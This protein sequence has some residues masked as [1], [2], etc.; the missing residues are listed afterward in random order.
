[1]C[2][3]TNSI[4]SKHNYFLRVFELKNKYRR[5][6]MKD[7]SKQ[8]IVRQLSSYLIEK[9]I[10]FRVISIEFEKSKGNCSNQLI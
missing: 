5:F 6:S 7:K 8:K 1:M 3:E 2:Y 4:L 10:G 9:H